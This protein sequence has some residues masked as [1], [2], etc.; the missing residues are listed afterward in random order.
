MSYLECVYITRVVSYDIYPALEIAGLIRYV[1]RLAGTK[2]GY[3]ADN[4]NCN[5]EADIAFFVHGFTSV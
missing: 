3:Y 5:P 1:H 4:Y 2:G